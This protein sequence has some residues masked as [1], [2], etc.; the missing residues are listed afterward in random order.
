[1]K[2]TEVSLSEMHHAARSRSFFYICSSFSCEIISTT[3][4]IKR[5]KE[6]ESKR[7]CRSRTRP[8]ISK[9]IRFLRVVKRRD[10]TQYHSKY[11]H[12]LCIKYNYKK[13]KEKE[14]KRFS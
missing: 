7:E 12:L 10:E 13:R 9:K 8:K 14:A 6:K 2:R 4:K 3:R 11:M 5:K 1:M